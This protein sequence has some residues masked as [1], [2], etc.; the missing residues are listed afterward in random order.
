M[1][2]C[3]T[4]YD[5]CY[6]VTHETEISSPTKKED[7]KETE[8]QTHEEEK[9]GDVDVDVDV[10]VD[11][12]DGDFVEIPAPPGGEDDEEYDDEPSDY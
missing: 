5:E 4:S 1:S 7:E 11:E 8:E 9:D 6:H 3:V 10:D 12:E 2:G